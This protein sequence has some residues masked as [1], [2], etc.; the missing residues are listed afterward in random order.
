MTEV[1]TPDIYRAHWHDPIKIKKFRDFFG[2]QKLGRVGNHTYFF[3]LS[4]IIRG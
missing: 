2:V 1:P 3:G 4:K